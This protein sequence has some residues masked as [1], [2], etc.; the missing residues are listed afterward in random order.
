[1]VSG[2]ELYEVLW[3]RGRRTAVITSLAKRLDTLEGK[4]IGELS[5]YMFHADDTFAII[6]EELTKRYSGIKFV[7]HELFGSI[8]G[9]EETRVISTL[10]DT[11]KQNNCDA[12]ITGNGC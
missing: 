11:L 4:T 10:A 2:K 3:P 12:V 6:E 8:H 1:M 9:S 5:D 7:K